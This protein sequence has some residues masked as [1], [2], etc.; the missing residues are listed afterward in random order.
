MPKQTSPLQGLRAIVIGAG[1]GGLSTAIELA[2][3]GATV[4]LFESSPD[5]KHQGDVIRFEA[6]ASRVMEPWGQVLGDA[7]KAAAPLEKLEIMNQDGRLLLEQPLD[8]LFDGYPNVYVNRGHVQKLMLDYAVSLGVEIKLGC[9]V[10]DVFESADIAG[11]R[12][13]GHTFEADCVLAADGVKSKARS[14]VTGKSDR[15][16]KSGFAIYRAWFPLDVF[17]Q[18]PAVAHLMHTDRPVCKL[19]I[20][21]DSHAILTTNLNMRAATCFLTHK[22]VS[23]VHEDWN[24]RGE[25]KDMLA[26]VTGWDPQLSQLIKLIPE[27]GLID[28]KM[29]WRDP[30]RKWV[31]D[32]GRTCLLGDAAHPHLP[33]SGTG[34]AQAFEDAAT[35]GALLVE[36]AQRSQ[37][38]R[39]D[40]PLVFRAYEKLR[41][42]RTSLTQ[43]MGWETRHVWHQ[44]DWD[45]VAK[46]PNFLRMPQPAWLLG[47]DA[48]KYAI[49][50]YDAIVSHLQLGTEFVAK[51][52]PDGHVHEDWTVEML[53][54][55]EG[56]KADKDFYK[57]RDWE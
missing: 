46:D 26:G 6:N 27:D 37:D 3:Y 55:R 48:R 8:T 35:I 24:Q 16:K 29:L 51:N 31:S 40:V 12:V 32:K 11:I 47:H 43:R 19:W 33:T 21:P 44:T 10:S 9:P 50:N 22:D 23:D 7:V 41:Y 18:E 54:D 28:H 20:A 5:L 38:T 42:E 56:R 49:D 15:P 25:V 4:Q 17:Q 45:A 1:F 13:R 52:T 2:R 14:A 34:A 57:V 36:S 53:L 30:V 39:P